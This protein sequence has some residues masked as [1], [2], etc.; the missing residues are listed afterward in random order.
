MADKKNRG[1]VDVFMQ[2]ESVNAMGNLRSVTRNAIVYGLNHAGAEKDI[3][4]KT[5]YTQKMEEQKQAVLDAKV[6]E[7]R[8]IQQQD[9]NLNST[10]RRLKE[11]G[12]T[13]MKMQNEEIYRNR[14]ND[15]KLQGIDKISAKTATN[16]FEELDSLSFR[17]EFTPEQQQQAKQLIA[18]LVLDKMV[19]F[20]HG[21]FCIRNS[22]I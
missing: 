10:V 8:N 7:E 1:P 3:A 15:E 14:S 2:R 16:A 6:T 18:E 12:I 19:Q 11:N 4:H 17:S 9:A 22:R 21:M 20:D 13:Q 5:E